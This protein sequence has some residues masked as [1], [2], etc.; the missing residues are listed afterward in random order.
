MSAS[1][2]SPLEISLAVNPHENLTAFRRAV[3]AKAS[4]LYPMHQPGGLLAVGITYT[5]AEWNG[6]HPP[7]NNVAVPRLIPE[8]P[9]NPQGA[10]GAGNIA[11]FNREVAM[12]N[13]F[14]S[15]SNI[16]KDL[17]L[18]AIGPLIRREL[19]D[20]NLGHANVTVTNIIEHVVQRYGALDSNNIKSLQAQLVFAFSSID[21]FLSD[22]Q[23][24]RGIYHQLQLTG[25]PKS[26]HDKI[27]Q[28]KQNCSHI[29]GAA[30]AMIHY[31]VITLY[32]QRTF[33]DMSDYIF[34]NAAIFA[35]YP[36]AI[37][38]FAGST[39]PLPVN[40]ESKIIQE[41]N[42]VTTTDI[43][44]TSNKDVMLLAIQALQTAIEKLPQKKDKTATNAKTTTAKVEKT[45]CYKHK[46]CNHSGENCTFMRNNSDFTDKMRSARSQEWANKNCV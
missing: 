38:P 6:I 16:L 21:T 45:W 40:N 12:F 25:N 15:D 31:E 41:V 8:Q 32:A 3:H 46:W 33:E 7:I 14:Y 24:M 20:D 10:G 11:I 23:R 2:S 44:S 26:M 22:C 1:V 36:S 37:H 4:L 5:N 34:Q 18:H 30:G 28:L 9:Q 17:M 39:I 42:S 19:E 35:A 29:P 27:E 13:Q 43:Y